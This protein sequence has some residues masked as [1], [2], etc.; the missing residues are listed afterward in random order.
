M[1][2]KPTRWDL[3][4]NPRGIAIIGAS[5]DLRRIGGQPVKLLSTFGYAG[6]VYPVNPKHQLRSRAK[7]TSA[8]P[9]CSGKRPTLPHRPL[10]LL[11]QP[12]SSLI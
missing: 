12:E 8:A 7:P 1:A 2:A 9:I 5:H 11:H 3:L 6:R 10:M 4:F